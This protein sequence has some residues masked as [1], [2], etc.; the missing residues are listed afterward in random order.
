MSRFHLLD[1]MLAHDD[2]FRDFFTTLTGGSASHDH[3]SGTHWG[4]VHHHGGVTGHMPPIRR[5][6]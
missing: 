2:N 3:L 4:H 6:S 5:L 1:R